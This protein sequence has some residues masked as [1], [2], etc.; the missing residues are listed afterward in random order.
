MEISMLEPKN[1]PLHSTEMVQI[2]PAE[3]IQP[4]REIPEKLSRAMRKAVPP[5][6]WS[7]MECKLRR[8]YNIR[9]GRSEEKAQAWVERETKDFQEAARNQ[10]AAV[11]ARAAAATL[12]A[13]AYVASRLLRN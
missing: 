3:P 1:V 12:A 5:E 2:S 8:G 11:I 4:D 13:A 10:L 6:H 7:D 9:L